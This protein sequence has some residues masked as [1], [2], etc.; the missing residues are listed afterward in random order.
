MVCGGLIV[1]GPTYTPYCPVEADYTDDPDLDLA[2]SG[3]HLPDPLYC[4]V[5]PASPANLEIWGIPASSRSASP[6][7]RQLS[8]A[9]TFPDGQEFT[10]VPAWTDTFHQWRHFHRIEPGTP[11][12]ARRTFGREIFVPDDINLMKAVQARLLHVPPAT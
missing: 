10:A 12:P 3:H 8:I 4:A 9:L 2:P 1:H 7:L 5:F 11:T 6:M